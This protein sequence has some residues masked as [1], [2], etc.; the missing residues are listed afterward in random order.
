MSFS[1][2]LPLFISL[3][4]PSLHLPPAERARAAAGVDVGATAVPGRQH[5]A[6]VRRRRR[7]RRAG[8]GV[9]AR[10]RRALTIAAPA[11]VSTVLRAALRPRQYP[12][13][14]AP[15]RAAPSPSRP[16]ER[17]GE[18]MQSGGRRPSIGDA[19][20]REKGR[21]GSAATWEK[22]LHGGGGLGGLGGAEVDSTGSV[23]RL[24]LVP[25]PPS[26]RVLASASPSPPSSRARHYDEHLENK[27]YASDLAKN[28]QLNKDDDDDILVDG[29]DGAL[30]DQ[31]D[32]DCEATYFVQHCPKNN[33]ADF[34]DIPPAARES[35]DAYITQAVS[36]A[37]L[38]A[39]CISTNLGLGDAV[40]RHAG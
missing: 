9:V 21:R 12:L 27:F 26:P 11:P 22:G 15:P 6:G 35:L 20:T 31:V 25:P 28:L 40:R 14:P 30:A 34:P 1:P 24:A 17:R 19:A 10:G 18:R 29:G 7:R 8:R 23:P 37:E 2:H 3:H 32:W 36:L 33:A 4:L 16:R 5:R 13:P 39:G 38:P